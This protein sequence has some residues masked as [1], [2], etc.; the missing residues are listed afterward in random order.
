M[1]DRHDAHGFWLDEAGSVAPAA[2]L[3][4]DLRAD[5][6]IVGGGYTGL[7]TAWELKRLEP[8]ARVVLLEAATCGEGPSGRNGGFCNALWFGLAAMRER[9]GDAGALEIAD[10]AQEAVDSIGSFCVEQGSRRLVSPVGLSAGLDR[11]RLGSSLGA[12]GRSLCRARSRRRLSAAERHR[13][14]GAL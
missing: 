9:F 2:R 3:A 11:A 6:V 8:E 13:G 12:G 7:W 1:A 14:A 5:V 4:G 10:A